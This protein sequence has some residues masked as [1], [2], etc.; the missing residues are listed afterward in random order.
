MGPTHYARAVRL[1]GRV[2]QWEL[3]AVRRRTG[4]AAAAREAKRLVREAQQ[5]MAACSQAALDHPLSLTA[6][7]EMLEV[8][9]AGGG[10]PKAVHNSVTN[11]LPC[12]RLAS[13]LGQQCTNAE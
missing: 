4:H 5:L 1:A 13:L 9:A 6:I 12:T 2:L 3:E 7:T 10:K 11:G 8:R